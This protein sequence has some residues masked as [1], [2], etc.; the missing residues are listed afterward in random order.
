MANYY[1][2][3][4]DGK[5]KRVVFAYDIKKIKY[6][7]VVDRSTFR[8]DSEQ[9]RM[10]HMTGQGSTGQPVYDAKQLPTDLEVQIRQGKFDKAEISQ[11]KLAKEKKL[12]ESIEQG[13]KA[14]AQKE[15][16]SIEQARQEYLD[17]ATGFKGSQQ[18]ES[19]T[20]S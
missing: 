16:E 4:K 3:A 17:K 10:F 20:S 12:N 5:S 19:T 7:D 14:K 13:K 11:M 9:V 6:D 18:T 8:P 1:S 15:K 2:V